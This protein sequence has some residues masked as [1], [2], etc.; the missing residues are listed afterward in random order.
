MYKQLIKTATMAYASGSLGA[1]LNSVALFLAA[2]VGLSTF[3]G[4]SIMTD[5]SLEWLYPRLVWGGVLA[6]LFVLPLYQTKWVVRGL[7][8]SI[9]PTI[10]HLFIVFPGQA[11]TLGGVE[12]IEVGVITLACVYVFNII[13]GL[14]TSYMLWIFKD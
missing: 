1:L 9:V 3:F 10:P 8:W 7:V 5:W 2:A 11:D 14:T 4:V 12:N 6:F 13:W